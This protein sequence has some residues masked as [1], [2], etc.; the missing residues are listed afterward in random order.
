M[1]LDPSRMPGHSRSSS[2]RPG[3]GSLGLSAMFCGTWHLGFQNPETSNY[4]ITLLSLGMLASKYIPST[5]QLA[6]AYHQHAE[7]EDAGDDLAKEL[8]GEYL[9][10]VTR[11]GNNMCMHICLIM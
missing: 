6:G 10:G 2:S 7:A 1:C 8:M 11:I 5:I 9:A 4:H 3:A